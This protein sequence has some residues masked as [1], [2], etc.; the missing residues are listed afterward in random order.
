MTSVLV[1]Q[2][3]EFSSGAFDARIVETGHY[4]VWAVLRERLGRKRGSIYRP[5]M[6]GWPPENDERVVDFGS[7]L[8]QSTWTDMDGSLIFSMA[9]GNGDRVRRNYL[10]PHLTSSGQ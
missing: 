6:R 4:L 7:G 2:G 9:S 3:L 5:S 10:S 1:G 8:A